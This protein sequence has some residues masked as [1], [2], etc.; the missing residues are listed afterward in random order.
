MIQATIYLKDG[1]AVGYRIHGHAESG[2]YGHD[3]VCAAVSAIAFGGAN[4]LE[5]LDAYECSKGDGEL[6]IRAK[7]EPSPHDAIVLE[8]VERQLRTLEESY[9]K[10]LQ[11]ERKNA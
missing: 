10:F 7:G 9:G 1:H 11:V 6:S 3:L 2:P 8:T 4:A 5:D